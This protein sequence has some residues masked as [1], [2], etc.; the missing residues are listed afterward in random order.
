MGTNPNFRDVLFAPLQRIFAEVEAAGEARELL[1]LLNPQLLAKA[2]EQGKRDAVAQWHHML[3]ASTKRHLS[4]W[5]SLHGAAIRQ[6]QQLWSALDDYDRNGVWQGI[7]LGATS[8]ETQIGA[9]VGGSL[10]GPIGA[11]IGAALGGFLAGSRKQEEIERAWQTFGAAIDQWLEQLYADY[12]QSILPLIQADFTRDRTTHRTKAQERSRS[13][14]RPFTMGLAIAI[15]AFAVLV[16]LILHWAV[17]AT[18]FK[19][20]LVSLGIKELLT[21]AKPLWI[22][23]V[24][25]LLAVGL[26]LRVDGTW[27]K[28][29]LT[30]AVVAALAH[31]EIQLV[32]WGMLARLGKSPTAAPLVEVTTP[33]VSPSSPTPPVPA[34]PLAGRWVSRSGL[35]LQASL[36]ARGDV[37]LKIVE[38]GDVASAGY[39]VGDLYATLK[40]SP[41]GSYLVEHRFRPTPPAGLVY[42]RGAADSCNEVISEVRGKPLTARLD[43]EKLRVQYPRIKVAPSSFKRRGRKIV[44][45]DELRR[46]SESVLEL[47]LERSTPPSLSPFPPVPVEGLPTAGGVDSN[48]GGPSGAGGLPPMPTSEPATFGPGSPPALYRPM[49]PVSEDECNPTSTMTFL[50]TE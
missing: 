37:E 26:A 14:D 41:D 21:S 12:D 22:Y 35:I 24:G 29:I 44:G 17:V 15:T 48:S 23:I 49:E 3:S 30:L 40:P 2:L 38:P 5:C 10:F 20:G 1:D 18:F 4:A 9:A 27:G 11:A 50:N 45:C 39:A 7:L 43:G 8:A 34:S 46:T 6:Y 47:V 42:D 31:F 19:E 28:K 13:M 33:A 25:G 16:L 32:G 36:D